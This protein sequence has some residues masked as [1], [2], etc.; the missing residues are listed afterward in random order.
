MN[1]LPLLNRTQVKAILKIPTE[2]AF[3]AFLKKQWIPAPVGRHK[4]TYLWCSDAIYKLAE[5]NQKLG[6]SFNKQMTQDIILDCVID[7]FEKQ[8]KY[9]A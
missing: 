6:I 3:Q 2:L 1:P 9:Y 5:R 4:K 7:A 8:A